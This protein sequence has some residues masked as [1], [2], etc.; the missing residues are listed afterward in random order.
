MRFATV[1]FTGNGRASA[2][3]DGTYLRI[4]GNGDGAADMLIEFAWVDPLRAGD[5]IFA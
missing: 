3:F 1:D 2:F 4:D 5:F